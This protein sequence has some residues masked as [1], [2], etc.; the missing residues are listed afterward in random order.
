MVNEF[1]SSRYATLA[2]QEWSE[3]LPRVVEQMDNPRAFFASLGEQ[4]S[5][6]LG[7]MYEQMSRQVPSNLPY[8]ERVG[9]LKTIRKQAEE[10]VLQ[11]VIFDPIA[12]SQIEDRSAREQLEEAL[13][14]APHPRDLEM[15]L[16]SIRHEAEDEAEDEGWEEVTYSQEQQ[17]RLDWMLQ[18]RPLIHLDPSQMSEESMLE[19]ATALRTL[20]SKRP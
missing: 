14:Q 5:V 3:H 7:Q 4:V 15:D 17:D 1:E 8:L 20:L 9:Q 10:L 2:R 6:R 16:I 13:G 11:E 19:A 12:Q 18:V